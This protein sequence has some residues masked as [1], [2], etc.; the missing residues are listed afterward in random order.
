MY[1]SYKTK[2]YHNIK[3]SNSNII[4]QN[5]GQNKGGVIVTFG[6]EQLKPPLMPIMGTY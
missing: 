3:Q 4:A 5:Y 1:E 2:S 6:L